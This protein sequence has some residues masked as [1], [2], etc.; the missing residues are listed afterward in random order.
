M[1]IHGQLNGHRFGLICGSGCA[2]DCVYRFGDLGDTFN[3]WSGHNC[4]RSGCAGHVRSGA[5]DSSNFNLTSSLLLL[6]LL[7][8]IR[9]I[10]TLV[11]PGG[12]RGG[13]WT[14]EKEKRE[15]FFI[16]KTFK[17]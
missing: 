10:F 17:E 3:H 2:G 16:K 12:L 8:Y 15:I 6:W 5:T 7:W 4:N 14:Y 9:F 11:F 13:R 1:S